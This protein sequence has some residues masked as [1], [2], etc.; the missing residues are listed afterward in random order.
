MSNATAHRV[1]HRTATVSPGGAFSSS[2]MVVMMIAT[3]SENISSL[4]M[5]ILI[6]VPFT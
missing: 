5:P 3:P 1:T 4:F 6:Q 2:T